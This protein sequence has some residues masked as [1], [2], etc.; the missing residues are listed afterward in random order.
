MDDHQNKEG[1]SRRCFLCKSA[2]CA[3]IPFGLKSLAMDMNTDEEKDMNPMELTTYCG[4]YCGACDIYQKRIGDAGRDLQKVMEAYKFGQYAHMIPGLEEYAAFEKVLG[5]MIQMFGQC[6]G[7]RGGG[8]DPGCKIR[9]CAREKGVTSCVEC[10]SVPCEHFSSFLEFNPAMKDEL[11][12][13]KE[14]GLNA[15]SLEQQ[16][17]VDQGFRNSDVLLQNAQAGE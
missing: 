15:W 4:L 17:K 13:I 16:K 7:C 11:A 12:R 2:V 9:L 3:L 10:P 5:N 1:I 8:G 14:I 6:A